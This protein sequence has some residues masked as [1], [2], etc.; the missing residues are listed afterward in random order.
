ML[1]DNPFHWFEETTYLSAYSAVAINY[2]DLVEW[3]ALQGERNFSAVTA[4]RIQFLRRIHIGWFRNVW[5]SIDRL[6]C[7]TIV[8]IDLQ[9]LGVEIL[10]GA[11]LKFSVN[12]PIMGTTTWYS[13]INAHRFA[14]AMY[15]RH[16]HR[17]AIR[18]KLCCVRAVLD[19]RLG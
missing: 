18:A 9:W 1:S 12:K 4:S 19:Q 17:A 14:F 13:D 15:L 6:H 3:F 2:F 10:Q 7:S 8:D 5:R 11:D 16:H